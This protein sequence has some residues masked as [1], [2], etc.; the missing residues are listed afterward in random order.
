MRIHYLCPSNEH[1]SFQ[2]EL[3]EIPWRC[4]GYIQH[5]HWNHDQGW[6]RRGERVSPSHVDGRY[7]FEIDIEG[8]NTSFTKAGQRRKPEERTDRL[9]QTRQYI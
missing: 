6:S 3:V 5:R 2:K 4:A 9:G 1:V 7:D 8:Y